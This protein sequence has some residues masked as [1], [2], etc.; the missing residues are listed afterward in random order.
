MTATVMIEIDAT[1]FF[2]NEGN[3]H[4]CVCHSTFNHCEACEF[5]VH[6]GDLSTDD[7]SL[8]ATIAEMTE[9]GCTPD[10]ID[11]YRQAAELGAVRV[12]FYA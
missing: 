11:A 6:V 5:I 9:G 3:I 2:A 12:L 10:F 8:A 7:N 1:D 4:W